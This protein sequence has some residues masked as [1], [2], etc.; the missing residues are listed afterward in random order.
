MK[1]HRISVRDQIRMGE[2]LF[3]VLAD[4]LVRMAFASGAKR[5]VT[6]RDLWND[7]VV[8]QYK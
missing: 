5:V 4:G 2:K 8:I 1:E 7:D 6:F 3:K